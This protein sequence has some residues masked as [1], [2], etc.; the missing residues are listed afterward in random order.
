MDMQALHRTTLLAPP[1][2]SFTHA[3]PDN[4]VLSPGQFESWLLLAERRWN[5][6]ILHWQNLRLSFSEICAGE[7]IRTDHFQAVAARLV[8]SEHQPHGF[9]G[10]LNDKQLAFVHFEIEEF[11]RLALFAG[12]VSF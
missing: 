9:K 1:A 4:F 5:R 7:K 11:P 10:P 3:L 6:P 8:C 12:Q 2:I